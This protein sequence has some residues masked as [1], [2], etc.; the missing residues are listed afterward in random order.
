MKKLFFLLF[1][2][3][4]FFSCYL[5]TPDVDLIFE[6]NSSVEITSIE[7]RDIVNDSEYSENI[8]SE[9]IPVSSK[10]RLTLPPGSYRFRFNSNTDNPFYS[11]DV[12]LLDVDYYKVEITD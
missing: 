9:T 8:L 2:F 7:Y 12:E 6:N 4:L 3:T 11:T 10:Y 5:F 1:V